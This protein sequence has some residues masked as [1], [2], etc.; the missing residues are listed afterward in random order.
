VKSDANCLQLRSPCDHPHN[1]PQTQVELIVAFDG[2]NN[3]LD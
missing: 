2:F 1:S 3:R